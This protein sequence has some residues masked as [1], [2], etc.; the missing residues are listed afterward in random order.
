MICPNCGAESNSR[1]CIRCG[2]AMNAGQGGYGN[3]NNAYGGSNAGCGNA[4]NAYGNPNMGYGNPNN[5]YGNPNMGY[6]NPNNAYGN[7]NMGYGNPNNAYGG[8]NMG[9]GNNRYNPN[10]GYGAPG[11]G[12]YN[13]FVQPSGFDGEG[14]EYLGI[15]FL[16]GIVLLFTLGIAYPWVYCRNLQ[17]RKYHTIINGRRLAFT[18]TAGEL[19]GNWIVWWL[20]CVVT[21]GIYGFWVGVRMH[22]WEMAHTC[23]A[24]MNPITGQTFANCYYDGDVGE[25]FG[26][27]MVAGL[28]T[29]FTCG[30][31]APWGIVRVLKYDMAHS[32]I[33]GDRLAFSGDGAELWGETHLIGLL[34]FITCGFYYS[35]GICRINRWAYRHTY[36]WSKGN[37]RNPDRM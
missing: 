14:A 6:G 5:A 19:F 17:W 37:I 16:N 28:I 9:Y 31:L 26:E 25:R 24:D 2:A 22:E 27:A 12:L 20:L 29:F 3:P 13:G 35:W 4:N 32:V 34:N 15:W 11:N 18:G 1:F 33:D 30:I 21:C 7:P 36:I 8:P 23:Y 10:M